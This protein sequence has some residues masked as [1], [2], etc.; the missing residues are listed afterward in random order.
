M[1]RVD[2]FEAV[3]RDLLRSP[4]HYGL[5]DKVMFERMKAL[6][7]FRCSGDELRCADGNGCECE[8][9]G[10]LPTYEEKP[11][12][13]VEKLASKVGVKYSGRE[14]CNLGVPFYA[15]T[16]DEIREFARQLMA[17]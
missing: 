11:T 14:S 17:K 3:V 9:S 16:A 12:T 6:A 15:F 7:D 4:E 8:M 10:K 1:P 13:D 5:A 2:S